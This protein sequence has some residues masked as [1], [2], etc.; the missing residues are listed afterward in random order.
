[1]IIESNV[2][3][4]YNSMN[5]SN[6]FNGSSYFLGNNKKRKSLQF[7]FRVMQ[8]KPCFQNQI[9]KNN[10]NFFCHSDQLHAT[11]HC[12]KKETIFVDLKPPLAKL[13]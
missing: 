4:D 2:L 1:M 8:T 12:L 5:I 3:I 6:F 7:P 13:T 10:K 11:K 9:T